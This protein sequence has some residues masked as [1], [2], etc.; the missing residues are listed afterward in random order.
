MADNLLNI[1]TTFGALAILQSDNGHEFVSKVIEELAL[2][3]KDLRIV[4]G[5][6][7]HPQSQASVERSNQDTKQLLG[8]P[9]QK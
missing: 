8:M 2:I 1:F 5:K 3:W 4:H 6:P 9:Y 7:R